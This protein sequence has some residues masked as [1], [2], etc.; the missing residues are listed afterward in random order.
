MS[1]KLLFLPSAR[2]EWDKLGSTV[3]E[4]F[5]KKLA[6]RIS[7]PVVPS[8]RLTGQKNYYKIKLRSSGYRLVYEVEKKTVSIFVIAVGKRDNSQV[9]KKALKRRR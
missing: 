6:E 7:D 3:R 4:Q 2:K 5:K 9:Y 8:D 1:Y